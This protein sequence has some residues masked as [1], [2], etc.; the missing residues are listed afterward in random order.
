MAKKNDQTSLIGTLDM[1]DQGVGIA[2]KKERIRLE[3]PTRMVALRD[4]LS[5]SPTQTRMETFNPDKYEKDAELLESVRLNGVAQPVMVKQMPKY[6][7]QEATYIQVFGHRRVAAARLAGLEYV[8][9]IVA[10]STADV[11]TLTIIENT[12]TR[13]LTGYERALALSVLKSTRSDLN[14]AGLA[15]VTGIP[16]PTVYSLLSAL[17]KSPEALRGL[18]SAGLGMRTYQ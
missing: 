15:H 5:A 14:G 9:A 8:P 16:Q 18:F 1:E 12:G 11:A 17:E 4:I 10:K 13:E 3:H 6:F 7:G 2:T